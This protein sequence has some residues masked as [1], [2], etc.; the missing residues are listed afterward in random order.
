VLVVREFPRTTWDIK[1][2]KSTL[3]RQGTDKGDYSKR[4]LLGLLVRSGGDCERFKVSQ[5][6]FCRREQGLCS[7]QATLL[8]VRLK[9]SL[10]N[11]NLEKG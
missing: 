10:T 6:N 1:G 9:V 11:K 3:I 8:E 4:T 5:E 2:L 7:E